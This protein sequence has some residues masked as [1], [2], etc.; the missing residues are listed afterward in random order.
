MWR[1]INILTSILFLTLSEQ[2]SAQIIE[3][4]ILQG[5]NLANGESEV[6]LSLGNRDNTNYYV[7][8]YLGSHRQKIGFTI[9]TR[10]SLLW[11]PGETCPT[12]I[13]RGYRYLE[14]FSTTVE[15]TDRIEDFTLDVGYIEG[16]IV[17]D[18]ISLVEDPPFGKLTAS[19]V[20]FLNF[21]YAEDMPNLDNTG[22]LGLSPYSSSSMSNDNFIKKLFE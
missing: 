13:C 15:N 12:N 19:R 6:D 9:D 22:L 18:Q 4:N 3:A 16:E 20:S 5:R 1:Q 11:V 8:L 17:K 10:S 7:S 14:W 2:T 21:Y